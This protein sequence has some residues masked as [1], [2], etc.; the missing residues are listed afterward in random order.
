MINKVKPLV[1]TKGISVYQFRKD[2]GIAQT[3]AYEL[4]N[5]PKHL[6]SIRVLE[7]IC[8]AY[9]IQPNDVIERLTWNKYQDMDS[10]A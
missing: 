4:Y 6:P 2:T 10:A 8:D 3:T 1:D 7:R 9:N 5:N